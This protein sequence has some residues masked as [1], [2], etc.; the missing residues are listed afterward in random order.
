M[1]C[2]TSK[3]SYL[4]Q[5]GINTVSKTKTDERP[6]ST[7]RDLER[8]LKSAVIKFGETHIVRTDILIAALKSVLE[9]TS[10]KEEK[11]VKLKAETI[12]TISQGG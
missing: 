6:E 12:N 1:D 7:Q 8:Y 11:C 2:A 5:R 9:L 3:E 4:T 10:A